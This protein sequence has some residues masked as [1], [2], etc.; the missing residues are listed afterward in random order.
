MTN[1]NIEI[2]NGVE[3]DTEKAQRMLKKIIFKEKNNLS[4][5]KL[6]NNEMIKEIKNMIEEEVKCY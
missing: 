3:V 5:G 6:S 2:V 4:T 1:N